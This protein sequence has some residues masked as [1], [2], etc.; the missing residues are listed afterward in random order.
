MVSAQSLVP[1]AVAVAVLV[2]IT[3]VT[4]WLAHVPV[5]RDIVVAAARGRPATLRRPT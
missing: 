2:A 3:L 4:L 5:R 1:V